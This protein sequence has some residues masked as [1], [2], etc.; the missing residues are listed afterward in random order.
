MTCYKCDVY[1]LSI[2]LWI[3]FVYQQQGS[4][5]LN[6][7]K[8]SWL[9]FFL[10]IWTLRMFIQVITWSYLANRTLWFTGDSHALLTLS[11]ALCHWRERNIFFIRWDRRGVTQPF[12]IEAQTIVIIS[13]AQYCVLLPLYLVINFTAGPHLNAT[14]RSW[15][16]SRVIE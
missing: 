9:I 13:G 1:L 4:I 10:N 14:M 16:D 5:V 8:P 12:Y 2:K 7:Q 3:I 11:V 6:V 15:D